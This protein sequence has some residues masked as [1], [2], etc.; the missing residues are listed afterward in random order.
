MNRLPHL[1]KNR[2]GVFYLR[3]ICGGR[4]AEKSLPTKTSAK[5]ESTRSPLIWRLRW[6]ARK[7]LI[8]N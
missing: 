4:E 6:A 5:L 1:Y 8:W 3:I 2:F 7:S